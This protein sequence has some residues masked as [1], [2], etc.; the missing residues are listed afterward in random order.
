[1]K[2]I[3]IGAVKNEGTEHILEVTHGNRSF[4]LEGILAQLWL[5]GRR[6]FAIAEG[7]VELRK[8]NQLK[9]MNLAVEADGSGAEEYRALT[10]C[11]L[12]PAQRKHPYWGL[13]GMEK[14]CL[15][16]I[17]EAGLVLSMAELT[18]IM[19]HQIPLQPGLLG[20]ENAQALVERIYTQD[21][22][23]DNILEN[24]MEYAKTRDDTVKAVL[25]LLKRKRIVLL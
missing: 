21:T 17:R 1:M 2:Y 9:R 25:T 4:R 22:I 10:R 6:G 5:N 20:S 18:Y 12:V 7:P 16:W 3:S 11:T 8:L 13:N 19:D 23:F 15:Q 24:Q 14:T